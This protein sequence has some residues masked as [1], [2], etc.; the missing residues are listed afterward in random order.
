MW[1]PV[2]AVTSLIFDEHLN[3]AVAATQKVI[4]RQAQRVTTSNIVS[5]FAPFGQH[6]KPIFG[7]GHIGGQQFAFG[8]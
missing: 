3:G 4:E 1:R 8:R 7:A 5:V 2:D 6:R